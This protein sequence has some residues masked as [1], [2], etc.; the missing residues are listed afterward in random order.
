MLVPLIVRSPP[1]SPAD[2]LSQVDSVRYATTLGTNAL[3][4]RKGPKVGAPE[5]AI[6]G[7]VKALATGTPAKGGENAQVKM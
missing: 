7:F 3:I 2:V 5:Q 1:P 6:A 4:E